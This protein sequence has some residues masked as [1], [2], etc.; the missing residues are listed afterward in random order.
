M[1]DAYRRLGN[2]EAERRGAGHGFTLD[3]THMEVERA[4]T[5]ILE[6]CV[7]KRR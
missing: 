4:R 5:A 1:A 7:V 2:R 6:H 3:S